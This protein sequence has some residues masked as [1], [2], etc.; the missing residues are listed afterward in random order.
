M[1][2]VSAPREVTW[3]LG[4]I[5]SA[6]RRGLRLLVAVTTTSPGVDRSPQV[7]RCRDSELVGARTAQTGDSTPGSQAQVRCC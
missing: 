2:P 4:R 6:L 1:P 5:H 3:V 7:R